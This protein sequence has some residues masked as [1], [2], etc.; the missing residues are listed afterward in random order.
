VAVG[1]VMNYLAHGP[2][3]FT[4]RR[5]ELGIA[6]AGCDFAQAIWELAQGFNVRGSHAG[7]AGGRRSEMADG[8]AEVGLVRHGFCPPLLSQDLLGSAIDDGLRWW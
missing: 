1:D 8:I 5:I 2:A 4:V 7:K 6:E 3:A